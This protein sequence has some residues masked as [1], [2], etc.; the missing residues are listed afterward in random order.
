[1]EVTSNTS[2]SIHFHASMNL[3]YTYTHIKSQKAP[4]AQH[5]NTLPAEIVTSDA[6]WCSKQYISNPWGQRSYRFPLLLLRHSKKFPIIGVTCC[7]KAAIIASFCFTI[8]ASFCFS[9]FSFHLVYRTIV[10]SQDPQYLP[11]CKG[12]LFRVIVLMEEKYL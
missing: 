7:G 10:M 4:K 8:T 9:I 11:T 12:P 3:F 2:F 1:M 5:N 6:Q